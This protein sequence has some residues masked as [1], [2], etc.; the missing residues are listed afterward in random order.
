MSNKCCICGINIPEGY[1]VCRN[2]RND[3]PV[4]VFIRDMKKKQTHKAQKKKRKQRKA[5]NG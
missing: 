2:C 1:H 3:D 4:E 5:Y